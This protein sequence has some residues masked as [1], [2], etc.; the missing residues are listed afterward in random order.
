MEKKYTH[1]CKG[2]CSKQVELT[3]DNSTLKIVD[4]VV[5]GGCNGN[6]KG[7]R[8]LLKGADMKDTYFRL[9]DVTCGP[10]NTSCPMQI[11]FT[12]QEALKEENITL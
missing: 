11:A 8:E 9:K 6:L 3:Y 7:I 1:I 2:T 5:T 4:V 12:I 10:R